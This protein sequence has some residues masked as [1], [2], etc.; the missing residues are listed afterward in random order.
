MYVEAAGRRQ[1][2]HCW[3]LALS[4]P[5]QH[6]AILLLAAHGADSNIGARDG[7][8]HA[9]TLAPFIILPAMVCTLYVAI[10]DFA[11][12]QRASPVGTGIPHT[13]RL[14][15]PVPEQ[16]P[17]LTKQLKGDRR[18]L[19]ELAG[20]CGRVPKVLEPFLDF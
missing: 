8:G 6:K 10:N 12:G 15:R 9:D 7:G 14:A 16:N 19:V 5:Y 2:G 3:F 13:S 20:E 17:G 18:V 1:A 4:R 11:K